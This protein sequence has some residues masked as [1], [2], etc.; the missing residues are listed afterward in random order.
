MVAAL[1]DW[2]LHENRRVDGGWQQRYER[3]IPTTDLVA[4][5]TAVSTGTG[6]HFQPSRDLAPLPQDAPRALSAAE[7]PWLRVDVADERQ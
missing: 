3:G 2:L 4:L 6:V 7:T 1:S 5:D